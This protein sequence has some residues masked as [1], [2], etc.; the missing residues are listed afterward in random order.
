MFLRILLGYRPLGNKILNGA[1]RLSR[2]LLLSSLPTLLPYPPLL[3]TT[4]PWSTP[5]PHNCFTRHSR[6]IAGNSAARCKVSRIIR[7]SRIAFTRVV[8]LSS[9]V[10]ID[11]F[12]FTGFTV[13]GALFRLACITCSEVYLCL[14]TFV[15]ACL[16]SSCLL[17]YFCTLSSSL[18][19]IDELFSR[20]ESRNLGTFFT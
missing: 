1:G 6:T 16:C 9:L 12:W 4:P 7:P 8:G 20:S 18:Q 17:F 2:E 13:L 10:T 5:T 15:K 14:C 19:Y 11:L 3:Q